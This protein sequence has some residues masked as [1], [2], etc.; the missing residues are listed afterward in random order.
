MYQK[1]WKLAYQITTQIDT[2]RRN[3]N[4][5]VNT[6][7]Q[8]LS[9]LC[10]GNNLRMVDVLEIHLGNTHF[11]LQITKK[12]RRLQYSIRSFLKNISSFLVKP[13]SYLSDH[14]QTVTNIQYSD[15]QQ[16]IKSKKKIKEYQ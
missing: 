13:L 1:R 3:F 15:S 14:C 16:I 8:S 9:E 4:S 6:N 7:G 10:E 11:S 12:H 2:Y 5:E